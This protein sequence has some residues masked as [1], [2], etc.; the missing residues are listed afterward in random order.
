VQTPALNRI[1]VE[2][3]L[4]RVT[5]EIRTAILR[6]DLAPGSRVKQEDLA[7]QLGVSREPV[8]QALLLL[9][10]EG[11]VNAR[12]NRSAQV[13]P[14]DRQFIA[15]LY[16]F[17]EA[18][19]TTVVA[20]LARAP[21][22]D[23][24]P[25][26]ELIARGR[27]AVRQGDLPALIDLDMS[28]HTT[29]YEAAGNHVIVDVMRGQ[30]SHIRRVMAM[31]LDRAIY[32]QKVWDEHQAILNAIHARRVA[33][34]KAVAGFHVRGARK[35]LLGLFDVAAGSTPRL[36][37]SPPFAEAQIDVSARPGPR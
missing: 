33:S 19:E 32:R 25:L 16:S 2:I 6:G 18:I 23:M 27:T 24:T 5:R 31:V 7:T 17:R 26:Q 4:A 14:L 29:L 11:L 10:R 20:T 21:R 1:P 37:K 28:F 34:A 3:L 8:R 36:R 12:P 30:W 15:D 13:A 22:F 35:M 9:Q